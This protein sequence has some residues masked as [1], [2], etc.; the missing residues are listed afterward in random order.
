MA[1]K[2]GSVVF[3]IVIISLIFIWVIF[4]NKIIEENKYDKVSITKSGEIIQVITNK[5]DIQRLISEINNSPRTLTLRKGFKY[6][7]LPHGVVTFE[8]QKE[9]IEVGIV[10]P[11]GN[12]LTRYWDI[13]TEFDLESEPK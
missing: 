11:I 7:Y 13:K 4:N 6:D 3:A 8:N 5:D 12:I 1:K 10:Y 9:K 2:I